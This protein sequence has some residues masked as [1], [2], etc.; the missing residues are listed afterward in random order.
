[1]VELNISL[2]L[3]TSILFLSSLIE[4]MNFHQFQKL[5]HHV[6]LSF[7]ELLF[8]NLKNTTVFQLLYKTTL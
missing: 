4:N 3:F 2:K 7:E 6:L 5:S 8:V 1:M